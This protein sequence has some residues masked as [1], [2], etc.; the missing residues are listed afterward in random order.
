MIEI[1]VLTFWIY[2]ISTEMLYSRSILKLQI[3]FAMTWI[4]IEPPTVFSGL[5]GYADFL[6]NVILFLL[7]TLK[8]MCLLDLLFI[9]FRAREI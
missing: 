2:F 8:I 7:N 9:P 6:K 5:L 3:L 4:Q 1:I